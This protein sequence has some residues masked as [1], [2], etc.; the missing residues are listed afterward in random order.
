MTASDRIFGTL[1]EHRRLAIAVLVVGLLAVSG[2][3]VFL[4]E[5]SGLGA[6]DM[7][8]EEEQ[9]MDY[10]DREF[11]P[12]DGDRE[13]AQVIV[14][15]DEDALDKETLIATLELQQAI[16]ENERIAPTLD[17]ERPT[18]GIA[19]VVARAAISET[20]DIS[21]PTLA[22][23]KS[24]LQAMSEDQVDV[25]LQRILSED[26][27][28]EAMAL[29]PADHEPGSPSAESTLVVVFQASEEEYAATSA[30]EE[31]VESH[32]AIQELADEHH[33]DAMVVGNGLITD[34]EQ[35]ALG[36]TMS[37]V[38]PIALLLVLGVLALA[39]RDVVDVVLGLVGIVL[40]QLW[41]FGMLGW[42]GMAFN[43][44]LMAVPVLLIGLSIDYCIHVFMRYREQRAEGLPVDTAMAAGLAGVGVALVWVTLTTAIGF[45]SNLASPMGPVRDLGLIAAIG[46]VGSFVVFGLFIPLL[47]VE[48]D[49]GLAGL[50]FDRSAPPIGAGDGVVASVLSIG[51]RAA[52]TAPVA[53]VVLTL[54]LTAGTAVAATNVSTTWG[55]E[56]NMVDGAPAWTA[57]LPGDMEPG[58][59]TVRDNIAYANEH[60]VRH[61][62]DGE[63]VV[64]GDVTDPTTLERIDRATDRAAEQEAVVV[65]GDGEPRTQNPLSAI[66]AVAAE[67]DSFAAT[68][69]AADADGDGIPDR[70]LAAVYDE[71]F[72][73]APDRADQVLHREDGEYQAY[74][75]AVSID[76]DAEGTEPAEQLAPVAAELEHD[77]VSVTVTGQPVLRG[78]IQETIQ[79]TLVVSFLLTFLAIV[80]VLALVFRLAQ[81]SATLGVVTILPV[82]AAV[83]WILGTMYVLGYPLSVLN[84]LVASLTIGI[85]IDYSIHVAE[86]FRHELRNGAGVDRAV[87]ATVRGTGAALLG[88]MATT[89]AGFGVLAFAIHPPLQQF[90]TITAIMI[91]YAFLGSV[92]VLPSLLVLWAR[93][94]GV[95]AAPDATESP[96]TSE[97]VSDPS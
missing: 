48:L 66:R 41:T 27:P 47:K 73:V 14:R 82:A 45:L 96:A 26:G 91:G 28:D 74:R 43:P 52:R 71:L 80:V 58:E 31:I 22:Q 83:S 42:L 32:L 85:G 16:R 63:L 87:T 13:V 78:L 69:D 39:Y 81:D 9:A 77:G 61:G 94:V 95:D 5:A 68:V 10:V 12:H 90:G 49:R 18:F 6:F 97:S 64:E 15:D 21:D 65:L 24:A 30:P 51:S 40:V 89:A 75:M 20:L 79:E 17:E 57:H 3:V 38:G 88:S 34:E 72:S 2:G 84:V 56:E 11:A 53:V 55:P 44:V 1:V 60:Y 33:D 8:T 25:V 36:D 35:R 67:H 37:V 7:G 50:G 4:E 29:V 70:N 19:N 86:R 93:F 92:L 76:G 23:Q 62:E 59:Y 46:I 54:L